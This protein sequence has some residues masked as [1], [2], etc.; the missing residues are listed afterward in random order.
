M[1]EE[2]FNNTLQHHMPNEENSLDENYWNT[3]YETKTTG[4][5]IGEVSPPLKSYIDT[6]ENKNA[7]ILIPGCG[8][9]YEA[10][11]LL[12]KGFTNITLIDIAP[13]L[14]EKLQNKFAGNSNI[15]IVLGDFFDHH[16]KYDYIIEQTFFCALPPS[17]RI[18]YVYKMS[19]LLNVKGV[20][21]GVLFN[22]VFE[23][24]PPFGGSKEEY[25]NLFAPVFNI[26]KMETCT[27]SIDARSNTELWFELQLKK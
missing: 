20:V 18:N 22:R 13:L 8:N 26:I 6:I 23:G 27:N 10:E 19:E 4:W 15:K 1:I 25:K 3:R 7:A 12:S 16:A 5:D 24:G 21:A 9:C 17:M 2:N 11:Y 14:V